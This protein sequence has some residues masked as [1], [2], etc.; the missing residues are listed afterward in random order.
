MATTLVSED[1][2]ARSGT[3]RSDVLG[4]GVVALLVLYNALTWLPHLSTPLG[5]SN[6][7]RI[8]A[9]FGLHV[10]NFWDLGPVDSAF[11]TSMQPYVFSSNYAHHPPFANIFEVATSAL[12]G[13]GEWQLR[14]YGYVSGLAAVV[15][16]ALLL[17]LVGFGWAP[18]LFAV[19]LTVTTNFF[20]IFARVGGG[21][22]TT[23]GLACAVVYLRNTERPTRAATLLS[24][25]AAF[26]A[27]MTSWPALATA[28]LLG[29]WLL[30]GRG[31][32]RVTIGMGAAML[33]AVGVSVGW[34]LNA[35]SLSDLSSQTELRT[36]G[37]F[38][39]GEFVERQWF[40]ATE[41]TPSWY[42]VVLFPAVAVGIADK[43]TRWLTLI[44]LGP[45][46]LWTFGGRQGA[47]N[48]EFWNLLWLPAIG[49]GAA[50]LFDRVGSWIPR[51][52]R[53]AVTGLAALVLAA[54]L[55]GIA[56][57]PAYD[58]YYGRSGDAGL[59][60]QENPLPA[61]QN[62][63]WSIENVPGARW[64]AYYWDVQPRPVTE[65][66]VSEIPPTHLVLIRTDLLPPW[67]PESVVSDVVAST[68]RYALV[69]A[70][71]IQSVVTDG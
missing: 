20:W 51:S 26:L 30:R 10:R 58:K 69:P 32:D 5:D 19:G 43:R 46:A 12:M 8:L 65:D 39:W 9:R 22:A 55:L 61:E 14:L 37:T 3:S 27:A 13:Q 42:R 53:M 33:L 56:T 45:A 63:G 38:T 66:V 4:W 71:S 15:L 24:L 36:G 41:L 25:V 23:L 28:A 16:L 18:T 11:A 7:G 47:F 1:A 31:L 60:L 62:R 21:F 6:E 57:G 64:M 2:P 17:R 34:I 54:G 49:V 52:G 29:L 35:T 50:A 68:G 40:R 59:L 67:L 44:L 48:H 70:A